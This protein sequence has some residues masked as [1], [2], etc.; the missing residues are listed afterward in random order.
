MNGMNEINIR[1]KNKTY[2]LK[3]IIDDDCIFIFTNGY[4]GNFAYILNKFIQGLSMGYIYNNTYREIDHWY[5]YSKT[6]N[7]YYDIRGKQ[8]QSDIIKNIYNNI[9]MNDIKFV[10][11]ITEEEY[12]SIG[13]WSHEND[14][15]VYN[16]IL[17]YIGKL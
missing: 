2:I 8:T 9:N 3:N 16:I 11:D 1:I 6:T 17:D 10:Y 12:N 15:F 13:L 4:C 14:K 7:L 5:L